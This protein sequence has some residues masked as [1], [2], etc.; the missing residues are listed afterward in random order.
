[1]NHLASQQISEWVAGERPAGAARHLDRCAECR[2]E[3]VRF[4][5]LVRD[6]RESAVRWSDH[7]HVTPAATRR[8]VWR[9]AA[10]GALAAALALGALILARPAPTVSAAEP[11]VEIPYTA[12]LAPYERT[13]VVRMNV[14]VTALVAAGFE[15]P[16]SDTGAVILMDVLVGQDGRAHAVRPIRKEISQ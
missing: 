1:M 12:P 13:T 10:A 4:D 7:V 9:V 15:V 8:R 6:F 3:L 14:P 2:A 16:T 5:R 11:F